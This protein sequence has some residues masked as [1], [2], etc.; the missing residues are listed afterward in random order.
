MGDLGYSGLLVYLL[1]TLMPTYPANFGLVLFALPYFAYSRCIGSGEIADRQ[2]R[3][4]LGYLQLPTEIPCPGLHIFFI[5]DSLYT[6]YTF[7][8]SASQLIAVQYNLS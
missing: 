2:V 3:L 4:S 5:T 7:V 6:C 8:K 1:S